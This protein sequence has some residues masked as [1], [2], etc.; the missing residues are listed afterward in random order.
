MLRMRL[1]R[2][3]KTKQ[4]Q[5]RV[6]VADQRAKRD[7]DFVEILGHY[8]PRTKPSTF[9]VHEDRVAH[10][11]AQGAQPSET[12][13][14]LLHERGLTTIALPT[15]VTKPSNADIAAAKAVADAAAAAAAEKAAAEKAAADAALAEQEKAAAEEA[16][17]QQAGAE[18]EFTENLDKPA[19]S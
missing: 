1:R 16:A 13:H 14:R 19:A 15:R 10:W 8:N 5:Y 9:E 6:I 18:A 12:V 7:G 11:L 17:V 2:V 4:P 3:G